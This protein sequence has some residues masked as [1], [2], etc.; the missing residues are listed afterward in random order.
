MPRQQPML[1][2]GFPPLEV[3]RELPSLPMF[4]EMRAFADEFHAANR[5]VLEDYAAR[6]SEDP[7]HRWSRRW[8]YLF[9]TE[10]V[11]SV[12]GRQPS[13]SLR[14]LDAGSGLT[15][16]PHW[17]AHRHP[18]LEVACPDRDPGI[19]PASR[20]LRPP[21]QEGVSYATQDLASLTYPDEA[22]ALISCVSVLE[23]TRNRDAII[24]EFARVLEPGGALVL[25]FDISPDGRWEIP[26]SEAHRLVGDLGQHFEPDADYRALLDDFDADGVLTTAW[27]REHDPSLLPWKYPHPADM[28]RRFPNVMEMFKPRFK[29]LTCFC[30]T[31]RKP[32]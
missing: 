15:F 28:V 27:A 20:E 6:W 10:R 24:G 26:P 12:H 2:Q 8:E 11:G 17:L 21:A 14:M 22:F 3:Y 9:V 5:D 7:L 31:W 19:A 13:G 1:P 25:T 32:E 30:G 16:F 4:R 23:H 18:G 29:L